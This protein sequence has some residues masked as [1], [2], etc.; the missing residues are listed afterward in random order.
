[1][2]GSRSSPGN[3]LRAL[4]LLFAAAAAP[5]Q[6]WARIEPGLELAFPADHGAHPA[7]RTEWWYATGQVES[8]EGERFGFQFTVFRQ[9]LDPRPPAPGDSPL[10]A[11]EALAAHLV[12]T[13]VQRGRT[14]FAER[15][16]R[17]GALASAAEGELELAVEDWAFSRSAGDRLTIK[18]RDPAREIGLELALVPSKPLV[19]HGE[20]GISAK[21][22]GPGNASAYASWTRLET[23]GRLWIDG[24]DETVRGE[25]W[26]DHEF[27][28]SVLGEAVGWDWFGLQLDDG[29]ELMLFR[30]IDAAGAITA[31]A[32]TLVARDGGTRALA[33]EDFAVESTARWTSPRS[34]ASYPARWTVSVPG[35]ALSLEV[36]PLVADCELETPSTG[37]IYWEG[38]V[39]VNG[40]VSGRGYVELTGRAGS[41][42]GRF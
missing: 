38:P 2:R 12:V 37:T 27:G 29:R 8:A 36:A 33:R 6:D 24:V 26:F 18:A 13:D 19:L 14:V 40:G 16:R 17:A 22:G 4:V 42:A 23:S 25:A 20:R 35:A 41:M 32:G 28:S 11:R 30:L 10:R 5:A 3:V 1:M 21:G 15:L 7:Y 39:A 34:G 31:A 9:G